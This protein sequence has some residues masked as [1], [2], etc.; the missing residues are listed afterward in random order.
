MLTG[1]LT[2]NEAAVAGGILGG[3]FAAVLAI[4]FVYYLLLVIAGWKI[5]EKA[6]EKGWKSLIPLYN[7]YIFY[8]IVGMKKWF[9]AMLIAS[10]AVSFV[11]SLMGQ[12]TQIQQI[13]MSTGTGIIALILMV[14]MC[15]F[16]FAMAVIYSIRT[17]KVFG[18]GTG[19]AVGLFLLQGIFLL[20]LGF[21]KSKYNKKLAKT[22]E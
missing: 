13:D 17:A 19:F 3:M 4:G 11:T 8:K 14:A 9:W 1:S 12:G 15:V 21:G 16:A 22:W 5:F 6:G 18:H 7:T 20:I 10:F 2:V